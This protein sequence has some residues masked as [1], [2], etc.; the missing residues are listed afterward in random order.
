VEAPEAA[1]RRSVDVAL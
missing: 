1:Q